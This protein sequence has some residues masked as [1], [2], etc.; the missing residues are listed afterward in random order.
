MSLFYIKK[1]NIS[2]KPIT[3]PHFGALKCVSRIRNI[4]ADDLGHSE[5]QRMDGLQ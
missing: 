3:T 2:R 5:V 4:V 1:L